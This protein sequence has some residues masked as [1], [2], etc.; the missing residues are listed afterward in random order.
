MMK[1]A[2]LLVPFF[3]CASSVTLHHLSRP[4][5]QQALSESQGNPDTSVAPYDEVSIRVEEPHGRE[6]SFSLGPDGFVAKNMT[7]KMLVFRAYG[8]QQSQVFGGPGWTDQIR[9]SILAKSGSPKPPRVTLSRE[10]QESYRLKTLLLV[11]RLLQDQFA[12]K[13]HR[14]D[15][16]M[17][18][19][20]LVV[21]KQG[22]KLRAADKDG[23]GKHRDIIPGSFN[24]PGTTVG[25]LAGYL[26]SSSG[27]D[28][29]VVE[30]NR[31]DGNVR[32]RPAVDALRH[33]RP[34][35]CSGGRFTESVGI[36]AGA[37]EKPRPD[38]GDR[39]SSHAKE[40]L[41]STFA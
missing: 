35:A 33:G 24:L 4:V 30:Q 32:H 27:I 41:K 10:E 2:V 26:T 5:A 20:A 21:A 15:K 36:K 25:E 28:R 6:N 17:S 39:R 11:Q 7:L 14:E 34:N 3:L 12:L 8:V 16:V 22:S 31:L 29:Q 40:E 23:A 13:L 1:S 37:T 9:F 19:Y 18:V 38:H